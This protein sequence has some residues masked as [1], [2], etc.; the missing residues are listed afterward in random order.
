MA[1]LTLARTE[2]TMTSREIASLTK[3]RHPDVKRDIE[4][5][6]GDLEEDASNFSRIYQDSMSRRQTEYALDRELTETLLT[7]YSA[8]LRRAVIARWRELEEATPKLL[9]LNDPY[10]LRAALLSYT[11]RVVALESKIEAD[12]PKVD[13][14]QAIRNVDGVCKIGDLGKTL[15]IGRTKFFRR[16]KNDGVLMANNLPYQKYI[17]RGY[18]TV[19]ENKPFTDSKGETH[20]TFTAMVTGAGQVFLVRRYAN[21]KEVV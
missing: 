7:G 6:L 2:Q 18:F 20:P 14:A 8:P 13:F 21:R 17:D 11:E 3:K 9:D 1:D 10:A 12:A 19:V 4:K 15:C 5:M 16:L